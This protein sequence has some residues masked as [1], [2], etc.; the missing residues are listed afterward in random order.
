MQGYYVT[1]ENT[2]N[3]YWF[4]LC[5]CIDSQVSWAVNDTVKCKFID[6]FQIHIPVKV[7]EGRTKI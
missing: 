3:M 7:P 2:S 6:L 1:S 5:T 4:L